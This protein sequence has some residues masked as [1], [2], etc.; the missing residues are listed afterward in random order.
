MK[1][2]THILDVIMTELELY[3]MTFSLFSFICINAVASLINLILS[4][5]QLFKTNDVVS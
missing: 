3:K 5:A 1:C 4:S 2:F